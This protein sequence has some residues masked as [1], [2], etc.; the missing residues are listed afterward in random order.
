MNTWHFLFSP[1]SLLSS[2]YGYGGIYY[3]GTMQVIQTLPW[4]ILTNWE[5]KLTSIQ[6]IIYI[7]VA[8]GL[9]TN[10]LIFMLRKEVILQLEVKKKLAH[11]LQ[12]VHSI[13]FCLF[14]LPSC[15]SWEMKATIGTWLDLL[16]KKT[17]PT[18]ILA[19]L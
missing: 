16:W 19:H 11:N 7:S 3:S 8:L 17:I 5:L 13:T 9:I 2:I 18:A 1:H 10:N 6:S 4:S 14:T 12:R 15:P